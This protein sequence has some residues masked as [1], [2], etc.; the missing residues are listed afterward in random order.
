MTSKPTGILGKARADAQR[1]RMAMTH[2]SGKFIPPPNR[3]PPISSTSIS[4][5]PNA[6]GYPAP[7]AI[8]GPRI[9]GPRSTSTSS[10]I[11]PSSSSSHPL[12]DII[13]GAY[14]TAEYI[15]RRSELPAH[16]VNLPSPAPQSVPQRFSTDPKRKFSTKVSADVPN[17]KPPE[18]SSPGARADFFGISPIS[19]GL[20]GAKR[21]RSERGDMGS[22][23]SPVKMARM[24][25]GGGNRSSPTSA[26]G[27]DTGSSRSVSV[28]G[29]A[30]GLY[31]SGRISADEA[32]K[33]KGVLFRSKPRSRTVGR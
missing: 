21:P 6:R 20:S 18:R 26:T 31:S 33:L 5:A 27:S 24:A 15:A 25:D 32:S 7:K 10:R 2:A 16:L 14:P 19:T 13:P 30:G 17:F 3:P 28:S 11:P 12:T 23:G 22:T 4:L 9:P 1:A 29:S 8:A